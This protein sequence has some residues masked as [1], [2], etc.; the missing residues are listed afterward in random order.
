MYLVA[1]Q[2]VIIYHYSYR[3][4]WIESLQI[5]ISPPDNLRG[6]MFFKTAD[7]REA[8]PYLDS[9]SVF[10]PFNKFDPTFYFLFTSQDGQIKWISHP[11]ARHKEPAV[12][13]PPPPCCDERCGYWYWLLGFGQECHLHLEFMER[14]PGKHSLRLSS[15]HSSV[16]YPFLHLLFFLWVKHSK[17]DCMSLF[18]ISTHSQ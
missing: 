9:A 2:K 13:R 3:S 16:D 6:N 14:T 5:N 8:F 11:L 15:Q 10:D 17:A 18:W 12:L 1:Q 4:T 7:L